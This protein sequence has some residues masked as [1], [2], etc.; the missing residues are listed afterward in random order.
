MRT[1]CSACGV[2]IRSRA[3]KHHIRPENFGKRL[4]VL[5][6]RGRFGEDHV[7]A[8]RP[9]AAALRLRSGGRAARAAGPLTCDLPHR[10]FSRWPR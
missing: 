9:G 5:P 6:A 7:E 4:I 10:G 2:R 8:D 1:N 3:G